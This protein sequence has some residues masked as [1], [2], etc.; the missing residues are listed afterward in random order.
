MNDSSWSG[1]RG[2][3]T[4]VKASRKDG[5][6]C[7]LLS[8]DPLEVEIMCK[9]CFREFPTFKFFKIS[10]IS[11]KGVYGFHSIFM[12]FGQFPIFDCV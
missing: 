6:L 2:E 1:F 12:Q 9:M 7:A 4:N 8:L 11:Q 10:G 3:F 5:A